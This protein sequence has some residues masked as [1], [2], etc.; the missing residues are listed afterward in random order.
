MLGKVKPT[1][2]H[3]SL[4]LALAALLWAAVLW[5][6]GIPIDREHLEP[7][8][9][10]VG[11][12]TCVAILFD[13]VLW[14]L[15]ALHGRL[16]RLPDLRGTWRVELTPTSSHQETATGANRGSVLAYAA[17]TQTFSRLQIHV[18]T[19]ESDSWLIAYSIIDSAAGNG[20]QVAG[21]YANKPQIHLRAER[22]QMHQGAF[23]LRTCGPPPR[24]TSLI[25]EYWTDR[26]TVGSMCLTS[27][28]SRV[29][30]RYPD[31][32]ELF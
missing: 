19:P 23:L 20:Y 29:V 18:M 4:F 17:V 7:F 12:L 14:R 11:A 31:A 13:R 26:N 28:L 24:P 8:G 22:S 3:I 21:I 10:V 16:V 15:P 6:R 1:R 9:L 25:G 27:R 32:A 30:T 5:R 2:L